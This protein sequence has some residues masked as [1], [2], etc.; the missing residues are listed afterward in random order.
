MVVGKGH[1]LFIFEFLAPKLGTEQV[2]NND[3]LFRGKTLTVLERSKRGS[4]SLIL[5]NDTHTSH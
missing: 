1:A 4:V 2:F 3:L 5:E